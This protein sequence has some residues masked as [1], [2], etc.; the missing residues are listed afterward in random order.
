MRGLRRVSIS[1]EGEAAPLLQAQTAPVIVA[2]YLL[3]RY[4]IRFA[5]IRAGIRLDQVIR[6]GHTEDFHT[7]HPHIL[8]NH[9]CIGSFATPIQRAQETNNIFLGLTP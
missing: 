3:G 8:P 1:K 2:G 6:L 9:I 7:P 5:L 4:E